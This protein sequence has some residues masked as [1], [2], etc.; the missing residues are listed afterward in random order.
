MHE[1]QNW[2]QNK[3]NAKE[4]L[5]KNAKSITTQHQKGPR[6]WWYLAL[7]WVSKVIQLNK[8]QNRMIEKFS[9]W[10]CW[11]GKKKTTRSD[12]V[13]PYDMWSIWYDF[14]AYMPWGCAQ[15]LVPRC[16][17][18][19]CGVIKIIQ[20]GSIQRHTKPYTKAHTQSRAKVITKWQKSYT[21][22]WN[23]CR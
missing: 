17:V 13:P 5:N 1:P 14:L 20:Q 21:A 4:K 16:R 6:S 19:L 8:N 3:T 10:L 18:L 12:G 11:E 9:K 2:P 23:V 7:Q 15:L 22:S